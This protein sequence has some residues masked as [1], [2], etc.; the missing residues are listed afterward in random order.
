MVIFKT[1]RQHLPAPGRTGSY[2]STSAS[3]GR[4]GIRLGER[5]EVVRPRVDAQD[6]AKARVLPNLLHRGRIINN[7]SNRPLMVGQRPKDAGG[8]CTNIP[9]APK[10]TWNRYIFGQGTL[11]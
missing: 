6:F 5:V 7:T 1:V 11:L 10:A 3:H 2:A 4:V 9:P 8:L